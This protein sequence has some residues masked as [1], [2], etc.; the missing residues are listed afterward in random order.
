MGT[1][2]NKIDFAVVFS[3]KGANPNGDPLNG[4]RPRT[5]YDGLG[6]LSDV[7]IKRKI[8]NRLMEMQNDKGKHT[9]SIFVQSDDNRLDDYRS[10][11][12]RVE[13]VLENAMNDEMKFREESC[14][15][16]IDVRSFGQVFAYKARK[17]EKSKKGNEVKGEPERKA[18]DAG[19]SIGIRG[20]VSI[21]SA[22]S[23]T[24]VSVSSIQITKSVSGEGDGTKKASDTMGMKHRV[25]HGVYVTYGAI[26]PQLASKTWFKD[27]DAKAIKN[28]LEHLFDNDASSARPEGS[29]E[30][31]AV[32]WW[33]HNCNNGQY[34]SAV[35]HRA[36]SVTSQKGVTDPN[37]IEDYSIKLKNLK[38]LEPEIFNPNNVVIERI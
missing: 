36:L 11:R 13:G 7:C 21:H 24:P 8:R 14:N 6:E 23:V 19:V 22:F 2:R 12:A 27:E 16:W 33:E 3:V 31:V 17:S 9:Y 37:K 15:K 38:G 28:A 25:D 34:S 26:N 18:D 30:V 1:L 4:N 32:I 5:N 20:P 35:V 29:M 10:L